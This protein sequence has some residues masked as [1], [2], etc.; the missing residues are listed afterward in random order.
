MVLLEAFAILIIVALVVLGLGLST[1]FG[2]VVRASSHSVGLSGGHDSRLSLT[3]SNLKRFL[4]HVL[5]KFK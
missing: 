1:L 4:N 3:V 2:P 5:I